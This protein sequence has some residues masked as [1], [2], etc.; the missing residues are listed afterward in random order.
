MRY[1]DLP[2]V[3]VEAK[4]AAPPEQVWPVV[5]D[6]TLPVEPAGELYDAQWIG[7]AVAPAV[8]AQFVG[9]NRSDFVGEWETVCTVI[10][11]EPGRRWVWSVGA[12]DMEPWAQWGFEVDP[13]RDG[14]VVRQFARIG[15]GWS[16]LKGAIDASPEKEGRI[17]AGRMAVLR[18]AMTANLE[19]VRRRCEAG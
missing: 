11:L 19:E 1:R 8:D 12:A 10:D 16:P 7:G 15:L 18:E 4:I 9:R 17:I 2:T 3:E 6:I 13:S 14:S 5:T